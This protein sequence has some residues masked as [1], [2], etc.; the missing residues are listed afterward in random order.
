VINL[1]DDK[2][3]YVIVALVAIVAVFGVVATANTVGGAFMGFG[4]QSGGSQ[5]GQSRGNF[6]MSGFQQGNF[7]R[8][9]FDTSGFQQGNFQGQIGGSSSGASERR[10]ALQDYI[11]PVKN[12]IRTSADTIK[13]NVQNQCDPRTCIDQCSSTYSNDQEALKTCGQGCMENFKSCTT[14]YKNQFNN[15]VRSCAQQYAPDPLNQCTDE[16][17]ASTSDLRGFASCSSDCIKTKWIDPAKACVEQCKSNVGSPSS[18]EEAMMAKEQFKT[19]SET[20]VSDLEQY[21]N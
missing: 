11:G 5:S 13:G 9:N 19:C 20:C 18:Q 7:D 1:A 2:V 3:L 10:A 15:E 21:I 17:D 16:C 14:Q 4:S 12:C 6:D 8:G